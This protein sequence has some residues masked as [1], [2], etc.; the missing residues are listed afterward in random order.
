MVSWSQQLEYRTQC[1]G[2]LNQTTHLGPCLDGPFEQ[3]SLFFYSQP[4]LHHSSQ[5]HRR[6]SL[7]SECLYPQKAQQRKQHPE[8][9]WGWASTCSLWS[10]WVWREDCP[11]KGEPWP[12]CGHGSHCMTPETARRPGWERE[13]T[14]QSGWG[15]EKFPSA[16]P[17]HNQVHCIS[18]VCKEIKWP[19]ITTQ[20][21]PVYN[22]FA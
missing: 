17:A 11:A 4:G 5:P 3:S 12:P 16:Q 21:E 18:W 14:A 9:S 1:K 22:G 6:N 20:K 8:G 19:I 7:Q 15:S 2:S 10:K 13:R